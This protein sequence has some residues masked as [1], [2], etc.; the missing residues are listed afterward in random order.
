MQVCLNIICDSISGCLMQLIH[1]KELCT[2]CKRSIGLC[3]TECFL[4]SVSW[5]S[6]YFSFSPG[7]KMLSCFQYRPL[8]GKRGGWSLFYTCLPL[9]WCLFPLFLHVIRK[10]RK[11]HRKWI[12]VTPPQPVRPTFSC[13]MHISYTSKHPLLLLNIVT[14]FNPDWSWS[15]IQIIMWLQAFLCFSLHSSGK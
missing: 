10:H 14:R 9:W 11:L 8:R 13:V 15:P 1:F 4:W 5:C 7:T 12:F 6:L 2:Q 3:A